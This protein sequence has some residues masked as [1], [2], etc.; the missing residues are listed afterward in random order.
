M[1]VL[2]VLVGNTICNMLARS[3]LINISFVGFVIIGDG[4]YTLY[5][6]LVKGVGCIL[7][8]GII[9][10]KRQSTC[11]NLNAFSDNRTIIPFLVLEYI[12][13][14]SEA[15]Y[16]EVVNCVRAITDFSLAEF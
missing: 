5:G 7:L 13:K 15:R 16:A 8:I 10:N 9:N 12:A 1:D 3:F 4:W 6:V 11:M 2:H 14:T